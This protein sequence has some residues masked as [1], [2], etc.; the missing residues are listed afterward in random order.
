MGLKQL[1]AEH[2]ELIKYMAQPN[3]GG[4]TYV[5]LGEM[6][7]VHHN[8]LYAWRKDPLFIAE[9]KR[10]VVI[11]TQES[12]SNIFKSMIDSAVEDR[13]AAAAKLVLEANDMLKSHH[14]IVT[15][16]K[17]HKDLDEIKARMELFKKAGLTVED[18]E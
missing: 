5:K 7:G 4:F 15:I 2:Y 6:I 9:L 18:K 8:T 12:L 10:Q 17:D 11:N 13:S 16:T 1:D 14:E 3:K